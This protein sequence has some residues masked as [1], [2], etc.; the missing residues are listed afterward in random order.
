MNLRVKLSVF[1]LTLRTNL[2]LHTVSST[3][4]RLEIPSFWEAVNQKFHTKGLFTAKRRIRQTLSRLRQSDLAIIGE[5][6]PL[7]TIITF[8]RLSEEEYIRDTGSKCKDK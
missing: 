6:V 5:H 3:Q 2:T 8:I 7:Y 1:E 4:E